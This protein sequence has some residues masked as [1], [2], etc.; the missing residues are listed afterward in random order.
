VTS[1]ATKKS[2]N[3]SNKDP[4]VDRQHH[5][6]GKKKPD[7]LRGCVWNQEHQQLEQENILPSYMQ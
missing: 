6:N 5:A 4:E 2:L 3:T 1:V 7:C